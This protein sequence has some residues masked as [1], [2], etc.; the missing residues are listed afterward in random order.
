[1]LAQS[2]LLS[3][4][5]CPRLPLGPGV[6]C[7]DS[8]VASGVRS[9]WGRLA[10]LHVVA[11]LRVDGGGLLLDWTATM[12]VCV[13]SWVPITGA[14]PPPLKDVAPY[15]YEILV[16]TS[17]MCIF[18]QKQVNSRSRQRFQCLSLVLM[19]VINI[20]K[21]PHIYTYTQL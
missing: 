18:T 20:S 21:R 1:M 14:F 13:C 5:C 3:L 4:S 6:C 7:V 2:R 8:A 11:S 16:S 12:C 15:M 10:A 19:N 17:C 9:W